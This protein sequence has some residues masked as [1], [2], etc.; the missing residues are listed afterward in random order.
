MTILKSDNY[1]H[2]FQ[3]KDTIEDAIHNHLLSLVREYV[4]LGGMP[5]VI[6]KYLETKSFLQCQEIQTSILS[7]FRHDFGKYASKAQHKYS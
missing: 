1:L 7:T 3:I 5:A 6:V 4:A 2:S